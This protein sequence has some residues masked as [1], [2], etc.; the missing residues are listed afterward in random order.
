M[1][2]KWPAIIA[3]LAFAVGAPIQAFA[4]DKAPKSYTRH[5]ASC[6]GKDGKGNTRA[7]R[8]SKAK[9]LTDAKYQATFDDEQMVKSIKEGIEVDGK[10]A[11]KGYKDK[12]S[13]SDIKEL[14]PFIRSLAKK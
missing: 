9:D 4:A 11:M 12:L 8:Q 2:L 7:G 13:A 10:E 5:C 14:V 1:R 3:T 6:H